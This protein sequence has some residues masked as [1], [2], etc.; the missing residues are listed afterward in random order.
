MKWW[1]MIW[2]GRGQAR[3]DNG[4]KEYWEAPVRV[5]GTADDVLVNDGRE[6]GLHE[7]IPIYA[8]AGLLLLAVSMLTPVAT[9]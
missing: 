4:V 6:L 8:N 1:R 7:Y 3:V 2:V 5:V 9:L